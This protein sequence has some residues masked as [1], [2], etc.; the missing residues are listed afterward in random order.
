VLRYGYLVVAAEGVPIDL[1]DQLDI[2]SDPVIFR[3][4][5]T[6][7]DVAMRFVR[8]LLLDVAA[9]IARLY[10]E[11]NVPII[12]SVEDCRVH[13]DKVMCDL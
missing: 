9:K 3:G 5:A 2:P 11:V 12:M 4:S 13:D 6:E 1:F 7:D 8:G 10:K